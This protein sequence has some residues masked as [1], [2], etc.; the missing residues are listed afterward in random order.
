MLRNMTFGAGLAFGL[1]AIATP[2]A[3]E[4]HEVIM[5]GVSFFPRVVYVDAGDTVRFV[6]ESGETQYIKGWHDTWAFGPIDA[7]TESTMT[8]PDGLQ[9]YFIGTTDE[10]A[11]Y[12]DFNGEDEPTAADGQL[13]FGAA[14]L[15]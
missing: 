5:L 3:A 11:S 14:P 7:G 13:H 4:E 2:A 10:D 8:V 1:T 15:G 12:K 9:G 6:N